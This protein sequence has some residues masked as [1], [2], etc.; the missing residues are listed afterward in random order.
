MAKIDWHRDFDG[1]SDEGDRAKRAFHKEAKAR[2]KKLAA[3]LGLAPGAFD[4]RTNLAGPASR[5]ETTLHG[6]RI[7]VQVGGLMNEILIRSCSGRKDFTG[8]QNNFA[9]VGQLDHLETLAFL[10]K[11][12]MR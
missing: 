1:Y 7:Y 5:G 8:G 11:G 2:L 10:V 9:N 3:A 6:E 4:L 12:I